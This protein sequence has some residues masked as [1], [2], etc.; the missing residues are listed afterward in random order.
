METFFEIYGTPIPVSTI[1][2]FRIIQREFIYRP[3]YTEAEKSIINALTR[4]KY[5]FSKMQPYAAI[6]DEKGHKSSMSEYK[7]KNFNSGR[8]FES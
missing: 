7:A 6:I 8:L 5:V 4:K 2:D 1:K 3:V